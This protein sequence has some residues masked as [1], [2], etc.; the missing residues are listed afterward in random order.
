[1]KTKDTLEIVWNSGDGQELCSGLY[2]CGWFPGGETG[3]CSQQI[4]EVFH[5]IGGICQFRDIEQH[6]TV[7]IVSV[8]MTQFPDDITWRQAV[9]ATFK[10][11]LNAGAGVAWAGGEDCSW[12]LEVLD[13]AS[14]AGNIY[15]AKTNAS[16]LLCNSALA[17]EIRYLSDEQLQSL[18]SVV[19]QLR[20]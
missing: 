4:R 19:Q 12:H 17:D 13:P 2:F 15:A 18:W 11:L 14:D 10:I 9:E 16:G 3:G 20:R 8:R 5:A 1:M 7:R 6:G